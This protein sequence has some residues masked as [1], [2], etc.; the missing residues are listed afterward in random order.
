MSL[1]FSAQLAQRNFDVSFEVEDGER[2][3]ILGPNGSGKSTLLAILAGILHPDSGFAQL[4]EDIF[5]DLPQI[6]PGTAKRRGVWTKPHTRGV[7]LLSQDPLLFPHMNVLDNVQFGPR[8]KGVGAPKALSEAKY[9]LK[10]V[11]IEGMGDRRPSQL[12]GGQ[13][14]RVGIARALAANPKLLLLDEPLAALDIAVA[15]QLRRV[16][17][18][19][20][21]GQTTLLVTHDLLD[22]ALLSDRIIVLEHGRIVEQ[23]PT[24]KLLSHPKTKFT[25]GLAGL[26]LVRGVFRA[27]AVESEGGFRIEGTLSSGGTPGGARLGPQGPERPDHTNAPDG[28][29]AAVFAPSAV[30]VFPSVVRGSPRNNL[31]VTIEDLEPKGNLITVRGVSAEGQLLSADVTLGSVADLDLYPGKRVVFSVKAAAVNIYEI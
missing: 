9:W 4:G 7:S 19:V 18:D 8:S 14:Q 6:S 3:A 31:W 20:L 16:L 23:G 21:Q 17:R 1:H 13:A 11:A 24:G 12:S 22:A 27:G 10:E 28:E 15:P 5:F 26:N 25:A 29:V 2:V 30:S